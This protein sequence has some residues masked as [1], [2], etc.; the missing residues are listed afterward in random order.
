[1]KIE[2]SVIFV[3]ENTKIYLCKIK[4]FVKLKIIVLM[5]GNTEMLR[6]AYVI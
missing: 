5:Q 3:K 4:N 1:M 2:N 6:I